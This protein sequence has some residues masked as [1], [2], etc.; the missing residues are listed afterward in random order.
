[1]SGRALPGLMAGG[2]W[3][4]PARPGCIGKAVQGHRVAVM[5]AQGVPT[6][7]EGDVAVRRGS[8]SIMPCDWNRPAATVEKCRG[9]WLVTGDRGIREGDYLR[10][11]GREDDVVTSAGYRIGPAE[12][13]DCLS[14]PAV[15]T[16]GVVGKPDA[17]CTQVVKAYVVRKPGVSVAAGTRQ[18][19]V[20]EQ[21]V[22]YLYPVEIE[23]LEALPV[24]VTGK[25]VRRA[26]KER[27]MAEAAQ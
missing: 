27:A 9:D 26:L 4:P 15:A 14:H 5:D 20:Q 22:T 12:I 8:A 1:M 3:D 7:K 6:D 10:F 21:L 23:F 24:T 19:R 16:C 17:V 25:V 11:V 18:K 13:E 2:V